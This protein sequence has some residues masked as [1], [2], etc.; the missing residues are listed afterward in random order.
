MGAGGSQ[1]APIS[2]W[3]SGGERGIRTPG[4]AMGTTDFESAAFDHS[5]ISPRSK[6]ECETRIL[7]GAA[8]ILSCPPMKGRSADGTVTEPSAFWKFSRI[9]TSVRPT[10]RPE[11]FSVC[12]SA[13]LPPACESAPACGAPETPRS[14]SAGDLAISVLRRQ[15]DLEVVG[16]GRTRIRCRR[17]KAT[18]RGR[19][20]EPLQDR[21]RV[22]Q[23]AP[24]GPRRSRG[25]LTVPVGLTNGVALRE[26]F[27]AAGAEMFVIVAPLEIQ[28]SDVGAAFPGAGLS[29]VRLDATDDELTTA[30][31]PARV[32]K[33]QWS[34]ATISSEVRP[35]TR[36]P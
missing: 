11:P 19:G 28:P 24:P 29:V 36:K 35:P 5:A 22:R 7:S 17:W 8:R 2:F 33:G 23:S 20:L 3:E 15:P 30:P 21:F 27:A 6:H 16:L 34:P 26:V 14:W 9:A 1:S 4:T 32:V 31:S 10:A 25:N 12:T 18:S 13:G